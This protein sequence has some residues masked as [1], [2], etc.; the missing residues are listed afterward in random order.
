[1]RAAFAMAFLFVAA[2]FAARGP[3]AANTEPRVESNVVYGMYSGLALLMDVY[4]PRKPNGY[5][6]INIPGSGWHLPMA[7]DSPQLKSS[8]RNQAFIARPLVEAG[9]TVFVVNHRAAPRFRHPASVEDVQRAVRFVRHHAAEYGIRA[10]R[11]G[12][13]GFSSGGHLALMLEVLDGKGDPEDPDPV[14]RESA[15]VQCVAAVS[16]PADFIRVDPRAGGAVV[17]YLGM[18]LVRTLDGQPAAPGTAEYR[19]YQDASPVTYVAPGDPPCLLIYGDADPIVPFRHGELMQEA[20]T[21][22]G[23]TV[24]LVR[25]KGGGHGPPFPKGEPDP[26]REMAQWFDEHLRG[27]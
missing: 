4:H 20:L 13:A 23:V 7:Y 14:N 16:G 22:A 18:P 6:L 11:L 3:E 1:M 15:K 9:Y 27:K 25:I 19:L 10:D 26:S 12:A 17:S 24:K 5:G 2:S 8:P 21:K